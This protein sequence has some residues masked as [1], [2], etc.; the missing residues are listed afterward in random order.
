MAFDLT[1]HFFS[2]TAPKESEDGIFPS[3]FLSAKSTEPDC[4]VYDKLMTPVQKLFLR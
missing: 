1:F 4:L 2:P 3:E